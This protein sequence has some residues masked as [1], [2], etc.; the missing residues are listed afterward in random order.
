MVIRKT[1]LPLVLLLVAVTTAA[2]PAFPCW[3]WL[4]ARSGE[5]VEVM[6]VG[7][8]YMHY[9]LTRD[10]L[11]MQYDEQ[12]LLVPL[13]EQDYA[14]MQHRATLR[15]HSNL[16]SQTSNLKSQIYCGTRRQLVLL[17]SFSDLTF[18][19]EQ[20]VL[21]WDNIFNQENF[22]MPPFHGSVHDYFYAQSYGQFNLQFDLYH[23][24]LAKPHGDYRSIGTDDSNAG[25]LLMDLLTAM[26]NEVADWSVYDWDGDGYVEQVLMLFAGQAQNDGGDSQTI[27]SH[28]WSLTGQDREPYAV[29]DANGTYYADNYGCF[30]ELSGRK[31]YGS[32]GTLCHEYGHCLGLPDFY[33]GTRKVVG[34]WDVMDYGNYND[35]GFC[36][37]GY[38]AHE[39]MVLGWLDV[40]ELTEPAAITDLKPLSQ[41]QQAYMIRN[42]GYANEYY[43]IENRQ[44]TGWDSSLPGSGVLIFHIDYDE[45]IWRTASP[46]TNREKRY[47]IFPANNNTTDY[48]GWAY[49]YEQ[50]DSLTNLSVPAAM[51]THLNAD[52]NYYMNHPIYNISITDGTASFDFMGDSPSSI[53]SPLV[54]PHST[55]SAIYDLQG[56]FMG[57]S[58]YLL[59]KGIYVVNGKLIIK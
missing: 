2:A 31:D 9:F 48:S 35:G 4:R 24:T 51:L 54:S 46:N 52:D 30:P 43:I 10:S 55:H 42:D 39:R 15:K 27:W 58:F 50:N 49:P 17:A 57:S 34:T 18:K 16:K 38:S 14:D 12:G 22:T 7:D 45:E 11:R 20:P 40:T 37:V 32:F 53:Q 33:Y 5:L 25:L 6:L 21:L 56:H 19:E 13:R 26:K 41:N 47:T 44:P 28:Q 59:P 36:P 1:I 29:T 3:Q 23:V 8:E